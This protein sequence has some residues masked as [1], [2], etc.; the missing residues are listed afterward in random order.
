MSKRQPQPSL[1]QAQGSQHHTNKTNETGESNCTRPHAT[2]GVS[3]SLLLCP[4]AS[5]T[6]S[7][8][9]FLATTDGSAAK[10]QS[11][12]NRKPSNPSNKSTFKTVKTHNEQ[13]QQLQRQQAPAARMVSEEERLKKMKKMSRVLGINIHQ[14]RDRQTGQTDKRVQSLLL[15][16]AL[17]AYRT[18]FTTGDDNIPSVYPSSRFRTT[19]RLLYN[20]TH[21]W[22]PS[23]SGFF[24]LLSPRAAP[25]FS[26]SLVTAVASSSP[27]PQSTAGASGQKPVRLRSRGNLQVE[28]RL[29]L[30]HLFAT[31]P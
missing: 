9:L 27:H 6:L 2:K 24:T 15:H 5:R 14:V 10:I 16:A 28:C 12:P 22:R 30:S 8:S 20:D 1:S 19:L 11:S 17:P 21:F 31:Y 4:S 18:W 3:L 25:G 23:F 7:L 13:Q 26:S 29:P